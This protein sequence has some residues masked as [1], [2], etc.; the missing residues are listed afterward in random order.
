M[1]KKVKILGFLFG[2]FLV[3][4]GGVYFYVST[5]I[6]PELIKQKLIEVVESELPE[7]KLEINEIDYSIFPTIKVN[8]KDFNLTLK[9]SGEKLFNV[10]EVNVSIPIL[11]ILTNGGNLEVNVSSPEM[12]YKQLSQKSDNWSLALKRK[13]KVDTNQTITSDSNND[14]E[15]KDSSNSQSEDDGKFELPPLIKKSKINVRF[16]DIQLFYTPLKQKS[17]TVNISKFLVKDINLESTTAFEIASDINFN[18]SDSQMLKTSLLVIG[19]V[20][21]P[22]FL[23]KKIIETSIKVDISKTSLTGL[24]FKIPNVKQNIKLKINP[25]GS[26]FA[27]IKSS[28]DDLLDLKFNVDLK[29]KNVEVRD[30]SSSL[31]LNKVAGYLPPEMVEQLKQINFQGSV[32]QTK[33]SVQVNLEPMKINPNLKIEMTKP[34]LLENI[35]GQ[36]FSNSLMVSLK[37]KNVVSEVKTEGFEG[38]IITKVST[39]VDPLNQSFELDKLSP[40]LVDIDGSN[41]RLRKVF[42]Q[43][44][45][46]GGKKGAGKAQEKSS[47]NNQAGSDNT[48]PA[49][50]DNTP[51]EK[52]SLPKIT[53]NI[54][55]NQFFIGDE[56]FNLDAKILANKNKANSEFFNFGIGAGKGSVGFNTLI[57]DTKNIDSDFKVNLKNI[58]FNSFGAFL[59]PMLGGV[60]GFFH[61]QIDG[62][63]QLMS[64]GL[65][66][67]INSDVS[68]V[69]GAFKD[70]DLAQF[71]MPLIDKVDLLKGKVKKEDLILSDKFDTFA[72]KGNASEKRIKIEKLE[73]IGPPKTLEVK[74]KGK[75][76][77]KETDPSLVDLEYKDKTGQL[78]P[79][80]KAVGKDTLPIRLIGNGFVIL[81]DHNYTIDKLAGEFLKNQFKAKKKEAEAKLKA[82]A[83]KK[84]KELERKAKKA[85]DKKKKELERKAK[86]AAKKEKKKLED[87]AKKALKG[88]FK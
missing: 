61:G 74:G 66:Y 63:V 35:M 59:P 9:K 23:K 12:H 1:S 58:N 67:N 48:T 38:V 72:F 6:K 36:K 17:S 76:S 32:I 27:D 70:L 13:D 18:L 85:A 54:K 45:L 5:V 71:I 22:Q 55:F 28:L 30:F 49:P 8:L 60:S 65:R 34:V 64:S 47:G 62:K 77:M 42:I 39:E 2:L 86:K 44:M 73:F 24:E 41:L 46:Y 57:K 52:I 50:I 78:T 31:H 84:K 20:D 83:A 3:C 81:P 15:K 40:I 75:V 87:K 19:Q 29:N 37:G 82:A 53:T 88:L 33:G 25:D 26:I 7:T 80:L 43:K 14:S 11:A 69:K 51:G 68:A 16:D 79:H 4:L 21:I 56:L 10:H